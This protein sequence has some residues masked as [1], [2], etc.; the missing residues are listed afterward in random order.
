MM[1]IITLMI[2]LSYYN[3]HPDDDNGYHDVS[4]YPNNA[5][6]EYYQENDWSQARSNE[7]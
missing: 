1:I 5:E 6:V 7:S 3:S 2:I 4:N